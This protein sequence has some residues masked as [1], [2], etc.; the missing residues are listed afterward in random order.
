MDDALEIARA[1]VDSLS[2]KDREAFTAL[3]AKEIDFRGVTPG[4]AWRATTPDEVAEI[5]FGSWFEPLDHVREV[6]DVSTHPVSERTAVAYRLRVESKGEMY[7]VE[8][9]GYMTVDEG[10]IASMSVVCSGYRPWTDSPVP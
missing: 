6:L 9:V 10:R 1:Y 2:S 4:S 8:Q 7:L 5:V 3:F